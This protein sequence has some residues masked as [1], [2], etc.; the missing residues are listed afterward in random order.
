MF[1]HSKKDDEGRGPWVVWVLNEWQPCLALSFVQSFATCPFITFQSCAHHN[2]LCYLRGYP[3]NLVRKIL[4]EVQF[5]SR[6]S[7]LRNKTRTSRPPLPFVTTYNPATPNLKKILMKHW[8]FINNQPN[9]ARIF[10]DPPIVS[11]R[12]EKSLK[13]YLVRA[14]ISSRE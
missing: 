13:D 3:H 6:Q 4:T 5:S 8:H 1:T 11:H 12:K 10:L 14:K 7:A 9:L 2:A